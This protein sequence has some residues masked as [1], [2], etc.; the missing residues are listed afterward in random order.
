MIV[1]TRDRL[2]LIRLYYRLRENPGLAKELGVQLSF[3][4]T[5]ETRQNQ[6]KED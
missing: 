2:A 4:K 3:Q 6:V 5:S 1:N